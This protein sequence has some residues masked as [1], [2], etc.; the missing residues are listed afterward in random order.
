MTY[1]F[2]ISCHLGFQKCFQAWKTL[3]WFRFH[4]PL[5]ALVLFK[6]LK[7]ILYNCGL[8][9]TESMAARYRLSSVLLGRYKQSGPT[10]QPYSQF[11]FLG[12]GHSSNETGTLS[13]DLLA[14]YQNNTQTIPWSQ[15]G[16]MQIIIALGTFPNGTKAHLL[17][18]VFWRAELLNLSAN[19]NRAI[20]RTQRPFCLTI[21]TKIEIFNNQ[22][23]TNSTGQSITYNKYDRNKTKTDPR[24][25][26][27]DPY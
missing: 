12:T 24:N 18:W 1:S 13:P 4:S 5:K 2:K 10:H 22:P 11:Y 26:G 7:V 16:A 14:S 23:H 17:E 3:Q 6:L 8:L 9:T 21:Y 19:K 27:S 20:Q 15:T 25:L